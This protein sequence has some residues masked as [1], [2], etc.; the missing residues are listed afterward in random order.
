MSS[1]RNRLFVV[2]AGMALLA[3]LSIGAVYVAT[4]TE[5]LDVRDAA[6]ITTDLYG[7]T[8]KLSNSIRDQ[9][10]ANDDYL[11][12]GSS[13]AAVRYSDAVA[14][15]LRVAERMRLEATPRRKRARTGVAS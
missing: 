10:A 7:L 3:S 1:V 11:L 13:D 6:R 5:R 12:S 14:N 4:E 9:E 2:I 8:V 15:E